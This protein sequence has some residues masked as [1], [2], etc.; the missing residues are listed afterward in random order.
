MRRRQAKTVAKAA[1][2][3]TRQTTAAGA[4]TEAEAVSTTAAPTSAT[5]TA[6]RPVVKP[7]IRR[8]AGIAASQTAKAVTQEANSA[9]TTKEKISS[10]NVAI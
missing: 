2:A 5:E 3:A 9:T 1:K 7:A 6:E 4:P 10:A 8:V